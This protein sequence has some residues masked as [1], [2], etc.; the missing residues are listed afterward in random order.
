MGTSQ[1]KGLQVVVRWTLRV[2]L[3]TACDLA[4]RML[5]RKR[6]LPSPLVG[7]G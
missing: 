1:Q 5:S 7:E 3:R 2:I 6:P 4:Q